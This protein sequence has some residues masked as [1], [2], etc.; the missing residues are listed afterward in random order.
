MSLVM[1][2]E[3]KARQTPGFSSNA[4]CDPIAQPPTIS[5]S[6]NSSIHI[7]RQSLSQHPHKSIRGTNYSAIIIHLNKYPLVAH[8]PY[9]YSIPASA[10]IPPR[11]RA[12]HPIPV[13]PT[14]PHAAALARTRRMSNTFSCS[15]RPA[16]AKAQ[17]PHNNVQ[18]SQAHPYPSSYV[19]R[20]HAG[21]LPHKY[22]S[23]SPSPSP[24]YPS[25]S[26]SPARNAR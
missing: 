23:P 21:K 11:C 4:T 5:A 13:L 6:A 20:M 17:A 24:I 16:G 15:R 7:H 3:D 18:S 14:R 22:P 25:A 8:R 19:H 12:P 1:G 26:I 2:E 9:A 10:G